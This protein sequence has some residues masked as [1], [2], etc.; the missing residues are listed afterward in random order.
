MNVN[1]TLQLLGNRIGKWRNEL[2]LDKNQDIHHLKNN[3]KQPFKPVKPHPFI[4]DIKKRGYDVI[5][6]N[7]FYH[8]FMRFHYKIDNFVPTIQ[9]THR[10][11]IKGD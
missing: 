10:S 11:P 5:D 1:S 8:K 7:V 6:V 4:H 9:L 2:E 3:Y